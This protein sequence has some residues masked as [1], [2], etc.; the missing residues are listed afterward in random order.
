MSIRYVTLG[1]N[2]NAI[3][4]IKLF[5]FT[6]NIY[7]NIRLNCK[8]K[9]TYISNDEFCVIGIWSKHDNYILLFTVIYMQ[10]NTCIQAYT[11]TRTCVSMYDWFARQTREKKSKFRVNCENVS[12]LARANRYHKQSRICGNRLT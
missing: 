4:F 11:H 10:C 6:W 2:S 1:C 7:S 9:L 5:M 8:S 3:K 12:N